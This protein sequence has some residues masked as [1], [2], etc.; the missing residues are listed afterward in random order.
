MAR[1]NPAA[2]EGVITAARELMTAKGYVATTV[3]QICEAAGVTKGTFFHYFASKEEIAGA[4][5]EGVY[6]PHMAAARTSPFFSKRDPLRRLDGFI[7]FIVATVRD[8]VKQSCLAGMFA[9]ELSDTHPELRQLC[10]IA[11]GDLRQ[12]VEEILIAVKAAYA[13][14]SRIDV[15][16]L[17]QHFVAVFQGG[18]IV[19]KA[20]RDTAPLATSLRHYGRYIRSLFSPA[21]AA[22]PPRRTPAR[23]R[24][25]SRS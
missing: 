6:K 3:D 13:P 19:A 14:R 8:P 7:E 18:L 15:G 22:S 25:A 21:T 2:R 16:D 9:Q 20:N 23:R 10:L 17:A 24:P 11:F 12:I 1:P 5:L 4:A